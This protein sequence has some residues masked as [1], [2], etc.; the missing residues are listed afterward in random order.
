MGD[1]S[2]LY[3]GGERPEYKVLSETAAH[4]LS[5][6]S[7][8][9]CLTKLEPEKKM[10]QRIMMHLTDDPAVIQYRC[11]VFEDILRFPGLRE[12]MQ[13]LLDRVDFLKT[14]GSFGKDTDAEGVWE[15][16]HRLDEMNEYIQC[17]QAIYECL[18]ENQIQ[19]EGLLSLKKYVKDLYEDHGFGELQKDIAQM[20]TDTSK[21]KSV[22][23]GVNLNDRYEPVEVGI[24]SINGKP[25]TKSGLISN[26]CDF[27]NRKDD[28][29][30]DNEWQEQY[31][32]RTSQGEPA[33]GKGM[34]QMASFMAS[35]GFSALPG[36]AKTGDDSRSGDVMR[37]LDRAVSAMLTRIVKKLK[38]VL[39]RHV[40][41][42]TQVISNL[43]P[44][45][46][47][48]IRWAEYVERL[49]KEGFSM[50]KPQV[51][52]PDE[53]GMQTEG[54]YNLRLAQAL[55]EK[56][57]GPDS[58][59][60]NDLDFSGE[61]RIYILTGANRG[62]K[63][64]I[65]QAVGLAFVL[66]QG[67]IYVPAEKFSFSP[68]DNIFT[69]YPAD[70]NQTMDLGRLGEESSRFRDIFK[71]AGK[72]SLLLLNESFS[73]TSFEEGYYIAR[74]VVRILKRL[75]VRT[76][77]NTHMHKLAREAEALN[78]EETGDSQIAS[79]VAETEDG[80][81]SDRVRVA[82]PSGLSYAHDIAEKYGVTYELLEKEKFG[83]N[84]GKKKLL[85]AV[86]FDMD[87][88]MFDTERI[89]QRSW[90]AAGPRL[91]YEPLGY[92]ITETIGLNLEGRREYFKNQYGEAFPFDQFTETYRS[93][94]A[95]IQKK[96]GLPIKP[97]LQELLDYLKSQDCKLAV[98]SSSSAQHVQENLKKAGVSQYFQ[99]VINGG[100]V[101]H[102][103]PDPQI[104]LMACQA[105]DVS[106]GEAIALED[107]PNGLRAAAA[108]G[109]MP[110]MV[111]DLVADGPK[112][113]ELELKAES[114]LEVKDYISKNFKINGKN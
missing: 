64:T 14:Y 19:S 16:V 1:F 96:E 3:P 105:L 36:M 6:E 109:M 80:Q 59:V 2:L 57:E 72:R 113:V 11:D 91:G 71:A 30:K 87:G 21:V 74:D 7:V 32:F 84:S 49:T 90:D 37:T 18:N 17:V 39:S 38:A 95:E 12:R 47:Y 68:A 92:R 41:V 58:I 35:R 52:P 62:G 51:C 104:Y 75:G 69:H 107:S 9:G 103:K 82:P 4:D 10:M 94:G 112:G 27:L 45:F 76:I 86:V 81:R 50:C 106:P 26:F 13:K 67:G 89:V 77:Y 53:R 20:K 5:L 33:A 65:T 108:A 23:L 22:T 48:Y 66:A 110:V 44:E 43:I 114:L 99:A 24:V 31:T 29:Q 70:E 88:L 61:H 79:L 34:E 100:Q 97:G 73:T 56:K 101:Q 25:F 93:I 42:S 8:I 85:K 40:A 98:A 102:S 15:L 78:K 55:S 54:L 46:L 60:P 111:P 28:I 63:T 83:S